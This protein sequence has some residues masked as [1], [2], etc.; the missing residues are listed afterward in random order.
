M[1]TSQHQVHK[2]TIFTSSVDF[3]LIDAIVSQNNEKAIWILNNSIVNGDIIFPFAA[4][5]GNLVVMKHLKSKDYEFNNSI[6]AN[7]CVSASINNNLDILRWLK[8]QDCPWGVC[9]PDHMHIIKTNNLV[10]SWLIDND[11]PW[12][13]LRK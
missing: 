13:R 12:I 4:R 9:I 5:N 3:P 7:A 2:S 11:C 1:T 10:Y 8:Q 6:F